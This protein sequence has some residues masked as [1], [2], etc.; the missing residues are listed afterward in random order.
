VKPTRSD[1]RD[2][3][4][5]YRQSHHV[6]HLLGLVFIAACGLSQVAAADWTRVGQVSGTDVFNVWAKGDTITASTDDTVFVSVDRGATWIASTKVA[7]DVTGI[8]AT[9]VH[10]GR[11]YAGTRGQGVFVSSDLGTTWQS[12]NQGLVGGFLNSQ[13]VIMDLL[14]RGDDLYASTG[15]SG[16]WTRNLAGAGGWSHFGSALEPAQAGNQESM[17]ASPSRLLAAGGGNGDVF[18]RDNGA[19]DWTESLL[20]ND[21]LAAGLAP[22]AAVWTGGS[23]LVGT[24]IGVFHS[25]TGQAP[26]TFFDFG[27]HPTLFS[28]FALHG[29]VVFTSVGFGGG[30]G[31][32]S[33]IDDGTTW[34]EFD[35]QPGIFT[36]S[37]EAVGDTLYEGRVDGLWRRP[38]DPAPVAG[39]PAVPAPASLRFA[40]AG[41]NP[42]R[43]VARFQFELPE[44]A[45][46]RI[47]VFD[48][49]GRR[50]PGGVEERLSAGSH[51]LRW[52]ARDLAPGVYVARLSAGGRSES[53]RFVRMR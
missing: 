10:N 50:T 37:I 12:F 43:D 17:G 40:I 33:S 18:F 39:V 52:E 8:E 6:A 49:G 31:L 15:G 20:F 41:A 38:I 7:P 9:K 27:V 4:S 48:V 24:N 13:L 23:W 1:R 16:V 34:I 28:S 26:W 25:T 14:L 53:V 51:E 22:L 5:K 29:S 44:A 46:V 36:Y 2:S 47:D 11:L 42:I 19:P 30:T 21:R 32:A 45:N 3:L 35:S